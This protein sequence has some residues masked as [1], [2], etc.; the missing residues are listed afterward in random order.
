MLKQ[1]INNKD[2]HFHLLAQHL[3]RDRKHL[4]YLM[5]DLQLLFNTFAD[6]EN[7]MRLMHKQMTKL[8]KD[9]GEKLM[10]EQMS[11]KS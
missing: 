8:N 3:E 9:L 7:D 1:K 5:Q 10:V 6:K 4:K 11:F 2:N